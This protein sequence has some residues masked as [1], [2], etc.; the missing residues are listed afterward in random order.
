M[1]HMRSV[2]MF[3][4]LKKQVRSRSEAGCVYLCPLPF[5]L[6]FDRTG[7][8]QAPRLSDHLPVG[9]RVTERASL[10]GNVSF[11]SSSSRW[12]AQCQSTFSSV[13]VVADAFF[14]AALSLEDCGWLA[15]VLI[16]KGPCWSKLAV[17][18]E[19]LHLP[20]M[21]KFADY[22]ERLSLRHA[23][24]TQRGTKCV[25]RIRRSSSPANSRWPDH[26]PRHKANA[27]RACCVSVSHCRPGV[28]STCRLV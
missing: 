21:L 13:G 10:A 4:V 20:V 6:D 3:F 23:G 17:S 19:S 26:L 1:P 25:S 18:T 24:C 7:L 15:E 22:N 14:R 5:R 16:C 11:S 27:P 2:L 9:F 8:G 28:R 12:S